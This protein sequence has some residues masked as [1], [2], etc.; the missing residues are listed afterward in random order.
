M[1]TPLSQTK[2]PTG[3]TRKHQLGA[4]LLHRHRTNL[5]LL[6][7]SPTIYLIFYIYVCFCPA[8][9]CVIDDISLVFRKVIDVLTHHPGAVFLGE[10]QVSFT[11]HPCELPIRHWLQ[12]R[13]LHGAGGGHGADMVAVGIYWADTA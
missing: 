5:D 13:D 10:S 6:A 4:V 9:N 12:H 3:V 8:N 1:K 2:L 11:S 7:L